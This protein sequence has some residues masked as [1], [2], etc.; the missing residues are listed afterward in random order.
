[1]TTRRRYPTDLT[2]QQW[3]QLYPLL[4]HKRAPEAQMREYVNGILSVLRTGCSWQMLPHDFPPFQ[5]VK[6]YF[7]KLERDGSWQW[8]HDALYAQVRQHAGRDPEPSLLIVD[9][10]SVK[11]TEKGG[12]EAMTAARK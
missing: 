2:D 12:H 10:Q 1:M 3:Q 9:S 6:T 5:T 8:V 4:S 7:Y 11:T